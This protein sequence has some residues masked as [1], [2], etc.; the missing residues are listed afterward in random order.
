MSDELETYSNPFFYNN[1][2]S[3]RILKGNITYNKTYPFVDIPNKILNAGDI[4]SEIDNISL[5]DAKKRA[6]KYPLIIG[7]YFQSDI[8]Q[9]HTDETIG[10]GVFYVYDP[11]GIEVISKSSDGGI[12]RYS[13][14]LKKKIQ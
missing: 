13:L 1:L 2:E 14:Y 12:N 8:G 5:L 9:I 4:E 3:D 7:F 10:K 11:L 6:I